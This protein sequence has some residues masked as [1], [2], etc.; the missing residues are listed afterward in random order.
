MVERSAV[1]VSFNAHPTSIAPLS[2]CT[3]TQSSSYCQTHDTNACLDVPANDY[4]EW[5]G[6]E[7]SPSLRTLGAIP[8]PSAS[9]TD[10]DTLKCAV[11][12]IGY[13]VDSTGDAKSKIFKGIGSAVW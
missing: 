3:D 12:K 9:L 7:V 8:D 11:P 13:Y 4:C 2:E 10:A 1:L 5:I 6:P